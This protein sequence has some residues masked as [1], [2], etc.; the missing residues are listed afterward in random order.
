MAPHSTAPRQGEGLDQLPLSPT[1]QQAIEK[2]ELQGARLFEIKSGDPVAGR[3]GL[4]ELEKD[5]RTRGFGLI[6][7][8]AAAALK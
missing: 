3:A 6:A 1:F 8:K 5:A 4:T 2:A 7:R